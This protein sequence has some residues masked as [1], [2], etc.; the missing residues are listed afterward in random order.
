MSK[1]IDAQLVKQA[2]IGYLTTHAVKS[3]GVSTEKDIDQMSEFELDEN[4]FTAGFRFIN[5][6]Q[7]KLV[8]IGVSLNN[9]D[10]TYHVA[11]INE[12]EV[13]PI[14]FIVLS[15]DNNR[16]VSLKDIERCFDLIVTKTKEILF[17]EPDTSTVIYRGRVGG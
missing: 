9:K 10:L 5:E 15:K 14:D 3:L 16:T 2:M 4:R 8:M 12:E 13:K 7:K 17:G 11:F 6:P 1:Q